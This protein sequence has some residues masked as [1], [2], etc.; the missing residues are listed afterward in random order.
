M[1]PGLEFFDG[2]GQ[3]LA[4]SQEPTAGGAPVE[5]MARTRA[6][7]RAL[8]YPKDY[9]WAKNAATPFARLKKP[10]AEARIAMIST[11]FPPGDWDE[12]DKP[13]PVGV[14]SLPVA[15]APPDLSTVR[16]AWD[17]ESTH[18]RDRESYLPLLAMQK[19]TDD[20]VIGGLTESFH[21]VPTTYSHRETNE[22][23]A[24]DILRRLQAE[25]A[26][27]ALLVPL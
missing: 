13:P 14:W 4:M 11:T 7:Y 18:T 27:A 9:V 16:R 8:G 20:G 26:D 22:Q 17:R 2:A 6:Y 24:P 12:D 23:A 3:T 25:H 5:Y 10:L 1:R 15:E 21:G 19:L